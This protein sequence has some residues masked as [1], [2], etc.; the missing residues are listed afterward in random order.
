[1]RHDAA[2]SDDRTSPN[3]H[4][5]EHNHVGSNPYVVLNYYGQRLY[6]VAQLFF[7]ECFGGI[8][9]PHAVVELMTVGVYNHDIGTDVDVVANQEAF[10]YPHSC[11]AHAHMVSYCDGCA[12][13]RKENTALISTERI[14]ATAICHVEIIA[15]RQAAPAYEQVRTAKNANV[16]AD[17]CARTAQQETVDS[18]R[19][20]N[21]QGSWQVE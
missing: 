16:P 15:N 13:L 12:R 7:G 8:R 3:G 19:K 20:P 1:M 14:D 9:P 17:S 21:A 2:R 5:L 4:S 18:G 6:T 10:L 11:A